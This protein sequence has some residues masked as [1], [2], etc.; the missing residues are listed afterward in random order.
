MMEALKPLGWP[1]LLTS[2][3]FW[4]GMQIMS[5]R[6]LWWAVLI[7]SRRR[8]CRCTS[9]SLG[10]CKGVWHRDKESISVR[11]GFSNWGTAWLK[12]VNWVVKTHMPCVQHAYWTTIKCTFVVEHCLACTR[13]RH[14]QQHGRC[15]SCCYSSIATARMSTIEYE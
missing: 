1:M 11:L 7:C 8:I 9:S 13:H 3:N 14:G 12:K 15:C 6:Y 4:E 2:F 5:C 10:Y